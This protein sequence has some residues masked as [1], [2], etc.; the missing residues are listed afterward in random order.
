MTF[1]TTL[2][3][4]DMNMITYDKICGHSNNIMDYIIT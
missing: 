4:Q 3:Y 2:Y 1:E